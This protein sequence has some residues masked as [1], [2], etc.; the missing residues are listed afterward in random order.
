[1]GQKGAM[2][3]NSLAIL[4]LCKKKWWLINGGTTYLS[5]G[6]TS[7]T[8][9]VETIDWTLLHSKKNKEELKC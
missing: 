9:L 6:R 1:M 4:I 5:V 8:D 7:N 2:P 3:I